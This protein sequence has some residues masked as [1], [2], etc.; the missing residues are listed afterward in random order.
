MGD[1]SSTRVSV[2]PPE[3]RAIEVGQ[4]WFAISTKVADVRETS[5]PPS[6]FA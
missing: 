1:S 5:Y 2:P 4:K 6:L 3:D